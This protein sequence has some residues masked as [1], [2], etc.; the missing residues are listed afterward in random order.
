MYKNEIYNPNET[1]PV[2]NTGIYLNP[3]QIIK[4]LENYT[5]NTTLEQR[6]QHIQTI[7]SVALILGLVL[8]L[9]TSR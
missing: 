6:R 7:G 5:K 9:S 2:G 1:I 3:Q 4:G 8:V